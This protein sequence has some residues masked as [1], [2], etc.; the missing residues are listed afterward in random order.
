MKHKED[1]LLK[2]LGDWNWP[3]AR[4][5]DCMECGQRDQFVKNDKLIETVRFLFTTKSQAATIIANF[6]DPLAILHVQ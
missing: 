4:V 6:K 1:E 2:E 3:R 5:L